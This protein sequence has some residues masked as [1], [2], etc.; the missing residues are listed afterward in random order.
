MIGVFVTGTDT[1]VGKTVVTAA[2]ACALRA[3]GKHVGVMKPVETGAAEGKDC[4]A[5]RLCR[6][7]ASSHLMEVVSPYRYR[8]PIAPLAAARRSGIRVEGDR[9]L[10]AYAQIAAQCDCMLV[11]GLGGVRVPLSDHWELRDL[12][13][14]LEL[15]AVIVARTGLGGINHAML[16]IE[17]LT[18]RSVP[19]LAL[20]LNHSHAAASTG[21]VEL[22]IETTIELIRDR[23]GLPVLG[24]LE[25][26]ATLSADWD[27]ALAGV[28]RSAAITALAD[29]LLRSG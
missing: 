5:E 8:E 27:G 26:T 17:A 9:L 7:A 28:S 12:I 21:D 16:T 1:G 23:A 29:L 3:R 13:A 19:I 20:V 24:P 25:H 4:D 2:L 15:P 14:A 10:S 11:E 6:A 22:Q 18:Q